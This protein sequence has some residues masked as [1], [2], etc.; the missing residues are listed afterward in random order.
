MWWNCHW[1]IKL[2]TEGINSYTPLEPQTG[3]N[4][5][6]KKRSGWRKKKIYLNTVVSI[7]NICSELWNICSIGIRYG[8]FTGNLQP[9]VWTLHNPFLLE[10]KLVILLKNI[11]Q[12]NEETREQT[13]LNLI[14]HCLNTLKI[15]WRAQKKSGPVST[16]HNSVSLWTVELNMQPKKSTIL[17]SQLKLRE[18]KSYIDYKS[19]SLTFNTTNLHR[20]KLI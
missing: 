8:A 6:Q 10:S 15:P 17:R 1:V 19:F 4:F 20:F 7:D 18:V 13:V 9:N 2:S 12:I 11:Q 5:S 3:N 14:C 16:M